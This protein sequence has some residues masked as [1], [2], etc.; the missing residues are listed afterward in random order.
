M[1]RCRRDDALLRPQSHAVCQRAWREDVVRHRHRLLNRH[2]R[3]R[4]RRAQLRTQKRHGE[5][6]GSPADDAHGGD[7][8]HG[9]CIVEPGAVGHR[10][11]LPRADIA[12]ISVLCDDGHKAGVRRSDGS[13]RIAKDDIIVRPE[14]AVKHRDNNG[15]CRTLPGINSRQ[16]R[17]VYVNQENVIVAV[18]LN[19]R[20]RHADNITVR[21]R[22]VRDNC[23]KRNGKFPQPRFAD[24]RLFNRFVEVQREG[25]GA[26]GE[27][28]RV[29]DDDIGGLG[30]GGGYQPH[31]VLPVALQ[32]GADVAPGDCDMIGRARVCRHGG[33]DSHSQK[34]TIGV[35]AAVVLAA[36]V[37]IDESSQLAHYPAGGDLHFRRPQS[38]ARLHIAAHGDAH[39]LKR[40]RDFRY[41]R[42]GERLHHRD[43]H[44]LGSDGRRLRMVV[45][46]GEVKAVC[47]RVLRFHKQSRARAVRRPLHLKRIR[48]AVIRRRHRH[49]DLHRGVFLF[50]Q[51]AQSVAVALKQLQRARA[52]N[53]VKFNAGADSV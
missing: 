3:R 16:H 32:F 48:R 29:A 24:L 11:Y 22:H 31:S 40:R 21:A 15:V 42:I 1:R 39:R 2:R 47:A 36:V 38:G 45:V 12:K 37:L 27:E 25:S 23:H 6:R 9:H 52:D 7:A 30:V 44:H 10:V 34:K 26:G 17:L 18:L 53:I 28:I 8:F 41:A 5:L 46:G 14:V 50:C 4:Q 43:R 51:K 19:H 20:A 33:D 35:C 13:L 49:R